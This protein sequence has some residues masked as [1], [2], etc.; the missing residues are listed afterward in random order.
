M[1][2]RP[3]G[4]TRTEVDNTAPTAAIDHV[5]RDML[6]QEHRCLQVHRVHEVH[7]EATKCRG[8]FG[9]LRVNAWE[10]RTNAMQSGGVAS[11]IGVLP[12]ALRKR[13]MRRTAVGKFRFS[14]SPNDASTPRMQECARYF[15]TSQATTRD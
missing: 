9:Y 6:H 11:G 4:G 12:R 3:K 13:L 1:A 7:F 10:V 8:E 14:L 5:T 2:S 15:S